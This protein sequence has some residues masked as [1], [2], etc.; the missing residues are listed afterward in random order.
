M[1]FLD[2]LVNDEVSIQSFEDIPGIDEL[3]WEIK[4]A[5]RPRDG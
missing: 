1:G 3:S 4:H 5:K 2:R